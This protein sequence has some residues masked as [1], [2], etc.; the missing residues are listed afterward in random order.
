MQIKTD[1][2]PIKLFYFYIGIIATFAYRIIIVL[3]FYE[4]ILVKVAWY[5]GTIGFI[6]YFWNRYKV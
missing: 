5:I 2:K 4:P 1:P 3:N 6:F